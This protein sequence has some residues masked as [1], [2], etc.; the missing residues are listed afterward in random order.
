MHCTPSRN[1]GEIAI[2]LTIQVAGGAGTAAADVIAPVVSTATMGLCALWA[3]A[4]LVLPWVVRG[5]SLAGDLV[6]AAMW[7]AALAAGAAS[8]AQAAHAPDPRGLIAGAVL[9]GAVAVAARTSA[10]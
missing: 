1:G 7:S 9:G 5:R 6:G 10:A 2:P 3:L 8:L 4:S